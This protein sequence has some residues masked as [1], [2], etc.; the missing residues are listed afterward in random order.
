MHLKNFFL[1][2]MEFLWTCSIARFSYDKVTHIP[3][4]NDKKKRLASVGCKQADISS[5]LVDF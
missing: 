1:F 4:L 2:H 5:M 3:L